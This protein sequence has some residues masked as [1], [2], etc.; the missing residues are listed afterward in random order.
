MK[1]IVL[2]GGGSAGHVTPNLALIPQLQRDGWEV[3]YIGTHKGMERGLVEGLP[4]V[5][6]H[7]IRSGKL[8]RYL[9]I[10]NFTDPFRVI[11]GAWEANRIIGQLKPAVVFAKGGF[12]SVPVAYGAWLHRVPLVLHESDMTPGLANKLCAPVAKVVC[13]T[14]PEAAKA[15]GS[16]G[17][18]TGTP[19]RP[20]LFGG[21]R[22]QGLAMCGFSPDLPVLMVTGGS[23]GASAVNAAVREALPRWTAQFQ[24]LHLCGKD[25]IDPSLE[26]MRGYRQF[27]YLKEE[28]PHAYAAADVL[29]S[30]AGSNTLSEIL[31]LRKPALLVPYP[32]TASRGDQIDN[33]RSLEKRGLVRV[34]M[35]EALTVDTLDAA[36]RDLYAN[37]GAYIAAMEQV[38]DGDGTQAVLQQIRKAARQ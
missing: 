5:A 12:V 2:T 16:K 33:A 36:L 10:Q 31:A 19:L 4:G 30:R 15:L 28:M 22:G 17:V 23:Q 29:L 6:Y 34:L 14:F 20:E 8:R 3:H 24:V 35:Q 7:P 11:A 37:R 18:C 13:T 21:K 26:G 27:A 1:R 32:A 25:H 9:D 38:E